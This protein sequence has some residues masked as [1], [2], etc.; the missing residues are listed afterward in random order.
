MN[1]IKKI[2]KNKYSKSAASQSPSGCSCSCSNKKSASKVIGYTDEQL[3]T[4]G[5]ADL[6]LGCGNPTAFSHIKN[7][8]VVLDL[9]SG[10]GIDCFLA[11][12]KSRPERKSHWP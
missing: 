5:S 6:G 9:G 4:V 10:A 11:A 12:K 1:D 3:K 2:V 8:D 7:G